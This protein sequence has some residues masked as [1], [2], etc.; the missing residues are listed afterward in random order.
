MDIRITM[1]LTK[2]LILPLFAIFMVSAACSTVERVTEDR[3]ADK[4]SLMVSETTNEAMI[5]L[6][7]GNRSRL[8]DSYNAQQHDMPEHLLEKASAGQN[9]NRDPRDGY[10]IQILSTRN[11]QLADSVS[12]QYENWAD[13]TI[14]GYQGE[15]YVSFKQ[16]FY[17][18]HIGDF[19]QRDQAIKYSNLIK[20]KYPDAWVVHDEIEPDSAPADTVSFELAERKE[21]TAKKE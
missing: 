5:S 2:Q 20:Q 15:A 7:D 9:I 13:T 16:P 1:K 14:T 18:V 17:K 8:R 10:R 19:Q 12:V 21:E 4:D 6:L 11:M 3:D